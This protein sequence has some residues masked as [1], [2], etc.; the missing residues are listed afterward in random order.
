LDSSRKLAINSSRVV[1]V[2]SLLTTTALP[3]KVPRR[4]VGVAPQARPRVRGQ[5]PY[6]LLPYI[7]NL[8]C[9]GNVVGAFFGKAS[10]H[11]AQGDENI[12]CFHFFLFPV[13]QIRILGHHNIR[14]P[15]IPAARKAD[16]VRLDDC[17]ATPLSRLRGLGSAA[18]ICGLSA[19]RAICET[20]GSM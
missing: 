18:T 1:A 4:L 8:S 15:G 14:S 13:F 10:Y 7:E 17:Q 20:I 6:H 16:A 12:F 3:R 11:V 2:P 5:S 19:Q 9:F